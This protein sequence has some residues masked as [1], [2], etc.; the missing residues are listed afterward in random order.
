MTPPPGNPQGKCPFSSPSRR[1]FLAAAGAVAAGALLDPRAR[2]SNAPGDPTRA[3]E[4]VS[5]R[6]VLG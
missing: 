2:G 6:T 3:A 1:G 5:I 4:R